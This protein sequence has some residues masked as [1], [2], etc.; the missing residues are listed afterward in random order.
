LN[1]IADSL[2]KIGTSL[3]FGYSRYF[4]ENKYSLIGLGNYSADVLIIALQN[5]GMEVTYFD[6]RKKAELEK[7]LYNPN[8]EGLLVN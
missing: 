2:P 7:I 1:Q 8:I 3:F 6:K 5:Q 4:Y